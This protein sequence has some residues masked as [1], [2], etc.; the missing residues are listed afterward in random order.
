M[1]PMC[2][3]MRNKNRI[4]V[5]G[6]CKTKQCEI[7]DIIKNKWILLK[8]KYNLSYHDDTWSAVCIW[9]DTKF[10][11]NIVF[12]ATKQ[13][14]KPFVEYIDLRESKRKWS[15]VCLD[16]KPLDFSTLFTDVRSGIHSLFCSN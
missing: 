3:K 14:Q 4:I 1:H 8:P 5:G 7:Y 2:C 11:N 16:N 13:Q 9:M 12:M 6:Q 15:I 10:D